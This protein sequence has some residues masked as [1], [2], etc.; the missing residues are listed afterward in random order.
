MK[1]FDPIIHVLRCCIKLASDIKPTGKYFDGKV[2]IITSANALISYAS[3]H[4][5]NPSRPHCSKTIC[6]LQLIVFF[7]DTCKKD[8]PVSLTP[9]PPPYIFVIAPYFVVAFLLDFPIFSHIHMRLSH[10]F[11]FKAVLR[12]TLVLKTGLF[13]GI[14][15]AIAFLSTRFSLQKNG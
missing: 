4:R 13:V 5:I 9:Y 1:E 15:Y 6:N 7:R 12:A 2:E 14:P 10:W 8:A 3:R 11:P